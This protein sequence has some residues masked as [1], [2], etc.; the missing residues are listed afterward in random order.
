MPSFLAF[1]TMKRM[2]IAV[3][4]PERTPPM[5]IIVENAAVFV[6]FSKMMKNNGTRIVRSQEIKCGLFKSYW[7]VWTMALFTA[8]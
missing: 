1:G 5:L 7:K 3:K 6:R 4:P 2:R 8:R